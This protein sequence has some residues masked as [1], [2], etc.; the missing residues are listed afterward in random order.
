MLLEIWNECYSKILYKF[1]QTHVLIIPIFF[2]FL[3]TEYV[4]ASLCA[5]RLIPQD[6]EVND[7]VSL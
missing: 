6:P 2:L 1:L 5:P 7:H 3:L 4:R